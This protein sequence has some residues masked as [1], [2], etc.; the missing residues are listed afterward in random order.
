MANPRTIAR[1]EA[2]I[3]E[4]AAHCLQFEIRDPRATFVTITKVELSP[5]ITSGRIH[6]SVLGGQAERS[7]AEHMLRSAAGFIQRQVAGVLSLR[8]M[9]HLRW[10]YDDS[11]EVADQMDRLIREARERDRAISGGEAAADLARPAAEDD[12]AEDDRDGGGEDHRDGP[13]PTS[14]ATET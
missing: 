3:H 2:R 8:R 12:D 5:D 9:P 14:R 6:W 13:A 10:V 4:R 1:L 7:K 11:L